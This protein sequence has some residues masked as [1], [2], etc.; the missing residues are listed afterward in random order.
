MAVTIAKFTRADEI[1]NGI[2]GSLD[3]REVSWWAILSEPVGPEGSDE[4]DA[5]IIAH[6]RTHTPDEW[7]GLPRT[8]INL[9]QTTPVAFLVTIS[10][11]LLDSQSGSAG[12][13]SPTVTTW[14]F[15]YSIDTQRVY[16]AIS[17]QK[18]G[19]NAPDHKKFI[20][21]VNDNGRMIVEGADSY[22]IRRTYRLRKSF[23]YTAFTTSYIDAIEGCVGKLNN[24]TYKGVPAGELLFL[25][26]RG[27]I[28][29]TGESE[30][31]FEFQRS[32]PPTLPIE[33]GGITIP[34]GTT[35]SGWDIV[36]QQ[37]RAQVDASVND[38]EAGAVGVYVAKHLESANFGVLN[39]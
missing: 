35:I 33:I 21:V 9:R 17:Q 18:F 13:E 19:S 24:A 37:S 31:S 34:T 8:G 2:S 26:A 29:S 4:G 25:G 36:W 39:L 28:A 30:L 38:L 23:P 10:Y 32:R 5:L 12:S 1:D 14:E 20:N 15:D 16:R 3:D 11:S 27:S 22:A 7:H 6:A